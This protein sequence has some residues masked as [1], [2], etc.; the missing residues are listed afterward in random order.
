EMTDPAAQPTIW[1]S[2][3]IVYT[4]KCGFGYQLSN[5]GVE[6]TFSNTLRLIMLP[7]GINMHCIDKNGEES[8]MTMNNYPAGHAKNIKLL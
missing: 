5:E 4:D 8:Y 3:W 2:K 6:V 1:V 7:N